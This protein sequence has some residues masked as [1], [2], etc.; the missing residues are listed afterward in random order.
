MSVYHIKLSRTLKLTPSS[1]E[2]LPNCQQW[3]G[4]TKYISASKFIKYGII[5]SYYYIHSTVLSLPN[6]MLM[7]DMW[8]STDIQSKWF[9][10][11]MPGFEWHTG[12]A[13][14]TSFYLVLYGEIS[15]APVK[16]ENYGFPQTISGNEGPM[17][18]TE[19]TC[20]VA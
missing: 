9:L 6:I 11:T 10:Q 13:E 3:V 18:Y 2:K 1:I 8:Y 4:F 14:A 15:S 7:R 17:G 20:F 5:N 19:A 16:L 12:Y